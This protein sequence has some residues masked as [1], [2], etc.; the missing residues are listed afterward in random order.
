MSMSIM[1]WLQAA[2]LSCD[3]A[4]LL[5]SQVCK[6]SVLVLVLVLVLLVLLVLVLVLVLVLLVL[7]VLVL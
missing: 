1:R 3:R 5:V 7:L 6:P 2:E 4:S